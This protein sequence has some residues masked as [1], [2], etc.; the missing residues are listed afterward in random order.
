M[1]K[2][3]DHAPLL[4]E[5]HVSF[6]NAEAESQSDDDLSPL[7]LSVTH[8]G[9]DVPAGVPKRTTGIVDGDQF[10]RELSL[11]ILEQCSGY[12]VICESQ[13]LYVD[14]NRGRLSDAVLSAAVAPAQA[15]MSASA[16]YEPMETTL[17]PAALIYEKFHETILNRIQKLAVVNKTAMLLDV[18][19]NSFE[20]L[21]G[22]VYVTGCLMQ[23]TGGKPIREELCS[24]MQAE[25]VTTNDD[26]RETGDGV[27]TGGFVTHYYGREVPNCY[28][29][30]LEVHVDFRRDAVSARECGV[31]IGKAVAKFLVDLKKTN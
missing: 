29:L 21:K 16:P 17:N 15:D 12:I 23:S 10:T 13:R 3:H 20:R 25:G 24:L 5:T 4:T 14:C 8:G 28:A 30:Q 7:I 11:A 1:N 2:N 9:Y 26:E 22:L 6:S 18:H 31:R 19:G 27:Y